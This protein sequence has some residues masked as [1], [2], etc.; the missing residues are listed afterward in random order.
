MLEYFLLGVVF[1]TATLV[2]NIIWTSLLYL[3]YTSRVN[4]IKKR[5]NDI[6]ESYIN[7]LL[8]SSETTNEDTTKH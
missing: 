2:A 3:F 7:S 6:F 1:V 8:A 5:S 4:K